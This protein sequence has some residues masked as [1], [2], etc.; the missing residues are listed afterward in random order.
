MLGLTGA[1][2]PALRVTERSVRWPELSRPLRIAHLTD[3]HVGWS[4]P[5]VL[6]HEVIETACAAEPDLVCLTGDYVNTG[7]R[8]L[9]EV[10]AF[11]AA[12]PS[13]VFAVLGNH[14]HFAGA[15]AVADALGRGGARVLRNQ[16]TQ[17]PGELDIVGVDDGFT[18]RD[19][20]E[21]AF[22]GLPLGAPAL[23]LAHFPP[24][25]ERIAPRG[26]RLVLAGHTHAGQIDLPFG[27]TATL[28]RLGGLGRYLR[29]EF[30][31]GSARMYVNAGLGHAHV[32]MRR[33]EACRPEIALFDLVP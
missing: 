27:V 33:G 30:V 23:V 20:P 24:S 13:P 2:R 26:G 32:G 15:D 28:A 21:R 12:L 6:L 4:T 31:L 11:V 8:F 19:E 9:P 14:D 10:E 17:G 5:P 1:R 18:G 22:D 16:R 3:L 7:T 25:F 29:G